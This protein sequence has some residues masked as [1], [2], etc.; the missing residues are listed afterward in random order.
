MLK[1]V[2]SVLQKR[3]AVVGVSQISSSSH[4]FYHSITSAET[5]HNVLPNKIQ[6]DSEFKQNYQHNLGAT[7]EL[8]QL[9]EKIKLGGG[10]KYRK[11]HTDR[12]KLLVRD[13]INKMLD[14]G[15][16]FLEFSQLAGYQ[17]YGK[18]EVPAGG[19][20]T[21]I[22]KIHNQL[23]VIVAND[24]TVKGGTYYP[25]TVKKH[26]RAQEIAEQNNLPCI[27]IADSGGA[28]LEHQADVFPDKLHFGRIFYNQ[29]QMSAK[30]IPQIAVVMGKCTAGGAYVL[31]RVTV[32]FI[33]VVHHLLRLPPVKRLLMKNWE[34]LTFTAD[35][36]VLLITLPTMKLKPS[37]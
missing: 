31:S 20:I 21:G 1:S 7:N 36:V 28:N 33:W 16:P 22:G 23:C 10:E 17:L 27:Y 4:R 5:T 8:K 2:S 14:D 35:K 3:S 13:R 24:A 30:G 15:S 19:I 25:I 11:M 18:D 32:P 29:A 37:I 34:V 12:N 6:P 26:L 9:I